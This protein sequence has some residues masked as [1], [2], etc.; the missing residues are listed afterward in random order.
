MTISTPIPGAQTVG[1]HL[2]QGLAPAR[3][4]SLEGKVV[5][6]TGGA[7][8]IAFGLAKGFAAAG[9]RLILA[10]QPLGKPA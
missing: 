8:G 2:F 4:F 6:I 10:A 9:A 1:Q 5:L 7:G 3:L